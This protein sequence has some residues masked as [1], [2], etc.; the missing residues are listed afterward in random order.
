MDA[1]IQFLTRIA[2]VKMTIFQNLEENSLSFCKCTKLYFIRGRTVHETNCI[3]GLCINA[4]EKMRKLLDRANH[5]YM[6]NLFW[7]KTQIRAV[8]ERVD[9]YKRVQG[10]REDA[11][12]YMTKFCLSSQDIY[13]ENQA[14]FG[15]EIDSHI[16][17]EELMLSDSLHLYI[18]RKIPLCFR[19]KTSNCL[20][21]D[22][23]LTLF[24]TWLQDEYMQYMTLNTG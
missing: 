17:C 2:K 12:K 13:Y 8:E 22:Y 10:L 23:F 21:W 11:D 19:D 5:V 15:G 7:A 6:M 20:P 1:F 3:V 16:L 24:D 14:L 18:S 4:W 9:E